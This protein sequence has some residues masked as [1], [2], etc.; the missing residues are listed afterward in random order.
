MDL[1]N[2]ETYENFTTDNTKEWFSKQQATEVS[3]N[4]P[5]KV[6]LNP[7]NLS[8]INPEICVEVAAQFLEEK[9]EE[10][11]LNRTKKKDK[12]TFKF[13]WT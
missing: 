13:V 1:R 12:K 6:K 4:E 7:I 2:G 10:D 8:R 9:D 3:R 5:I 11:D